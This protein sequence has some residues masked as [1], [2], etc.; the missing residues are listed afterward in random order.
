MSVARMRVAWPA[1]LATIAFGLAACGSDSGGAN[2]DVATAT[3]PV[4]TTPAG[5]PLRIGTKNF[6]E[7][8]ILG[9]LYA[10]A[11]RAKGI[12]VRL[13]SNIG[14]SEVTHQALVNGTIDMYPEYIGTLL[15]EI[16]QD[17]NRPRSPDAAYQ[18]AKKF[19]EGNGFTLLT[20]TPFSD[21]EALAVTPKYARRH[22]ASSL[23]DLKRLA[24]KV[25]IGAPKEF[26][27]RFEGLVGLEQVYGVHK[28]RFS[29]LGFGDRYS[30]LDSGRVD[31]AAVFT[32]ESQLAGKRYQVLDD[33]KGLFAL[34]HAAPII[35]KKALAAH[36]PRL[37]AVVDAV[38]AKLTTA[39]MLRL[40][41][42]VD[43]AHRTPRA[44]ATEFL[45]AQGL[46]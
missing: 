12:A 5:P 40:N 32:T 9:E 46:L 44:V 19:E 11:L 13:T 38:S 23:A 45:R 4:V 24:P 27:A 28:P 35:S 43:I 15:S 22:S 18:R 14:S 6:T 8:F 20:P 17:T 41:A 16:A 30:S 1:L 29:R 21:S 33:P 10:Q 36:G 34:Q 25:R 31:V 37:Q 3:T 39:R 26:S 42:A 7:E 2:V